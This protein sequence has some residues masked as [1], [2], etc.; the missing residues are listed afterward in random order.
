MRRRRCLHNRK[1]MSPSP[2]LCDI[3]SELDTEL[4]MTVQEHLKIDEKNQPK[5]HQPGTSSRIMT[6][7]ASTQ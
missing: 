2:C 5:S 6:H 4:L 3:N 7:L 1:K